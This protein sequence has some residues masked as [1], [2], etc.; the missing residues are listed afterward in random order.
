[1][2]G[3][4]SI[5]HQQQQQQQMGNQNY[6][7]PSPAAMIGVLSTGSGPEGGGLVGGSGGFSGP[8]TI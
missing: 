3:S 1:M 5:P 6:L 4:Q 8:Q 2:P 7:N